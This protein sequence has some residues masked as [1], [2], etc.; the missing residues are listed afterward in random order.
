MANKTGVYDFSKCIVLIKHPLYDGVIP[1]DGFMNDTSI[2]VA[3]TDP[4][5]ANNASGDGKASTLVRNPV[6]AGTITFTLNQST[7]SLAKLNAIAKH[8]DISDGSDLLFE[9]TVADKS[10]GSFHFS[11]DAIVGDPESVEYGRDENG[12]EFQIQCGSLSNNLNG[13]A[14]VPQETLRIVQALGFNLDESRVAD[15]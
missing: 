9:I 15:Y 13:S 6:D 5:W 10:S 3:R 7:D 1:I 12:R 14:K 4:R 2:V 11:R 8:A